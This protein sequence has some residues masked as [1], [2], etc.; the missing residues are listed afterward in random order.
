MKFKCAEA[1]KV[2]RTVSGPEQTLCSY[3]SR[4]YLVLFWGWPVDE[5]ISAHASKRAFSA[6]SVNSRVFCDGKVS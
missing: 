4:W 5:H 2:L 1:Q 6:L 3:Y